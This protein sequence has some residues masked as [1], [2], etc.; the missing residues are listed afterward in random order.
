MTEI[1]TVKRTCDKCGSGIN[2]G[3]MF[4]RAYADGSETPG[5][6]MAGG[7]P[8]RPEWIPNEDLP[9][10]LDFCQEC[11][12]EMFGELIWKVAKERREERHNQ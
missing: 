6:G 1:V 2:P 11:A 10:S 7:T 4:W 3:S 5:F 8:L 12:A 9:D